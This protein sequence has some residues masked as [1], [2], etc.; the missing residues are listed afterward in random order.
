MRER[1]ADEVARDI[2]MAK[3]EAERLLAEQVAW[4]LEV[5][6]CR[7]Q[8]YQAV[9]CLTHA[10]GGRVRF[11]AC[12]FACAFACHIACQMQHCLPQLGLRCH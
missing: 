8:L 7:H 4:D 12:R 3:V 1:A 10:D 2:E 9:R 6:S 11:A 5:R